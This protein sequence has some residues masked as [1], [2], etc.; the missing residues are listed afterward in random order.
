MNFD[1][2][3]SE[4]KRKSVGFAF[5]RSKPLQGDRGANSMLINRTFNSPKK[6]VD[7]EVETRKIK[8]FKTNMS[9][10]ND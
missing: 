5:Q 7:D 3:T 10:L 9:T 6:D 2:A 1:T 4:N 8:N